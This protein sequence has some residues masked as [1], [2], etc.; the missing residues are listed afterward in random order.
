MA[1]ALHWLLHAT[2]VRRPIMRA[3][4]HFINQTLLRVPRYR[5]YLV[6]YGGVGLSIVV[7][8]I[9]RFTT[10][11]QQVRAEVSADGARVAIGIVA[12]WVIAGL[13]TAFVSSGNRPG[14]WIWRMVQGRPP[15]F[16]AAMEQ[17]LAAKVWAALCGMAVTGAIIGGLRLVA[18][19][20][21][22]AFPAIAAQA[23]VAAGMCLLLTDVFFLNVMTVPFTGESTHEQENLAF[24]LLRNFTLFPLV[25]WLSLV[26][27][28][29]IEMSWLHLGMGAAAIVVAHLWL[30]KRH[31]DGVRLHSRQPELE[32]GEEGFPMKLGLRY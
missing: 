17:L 22:L 26:S 21:L 24:T 25:T 15:H 23:L 3:V 11:H 7:A 2:F 30:R 6:L 1:A 19:P 27:E 16:E 12:F 9:L 31:L 28:H 8:T 13:R 32:E 4:F 10:R 14:S 29:W 20:E 18:P 5:I